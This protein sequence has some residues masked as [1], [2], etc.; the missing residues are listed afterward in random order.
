[1]I[2]S[3]SL[4]GDGCARASGP[5]TPRVTGASRAFDV[6]YER[7]W[8]AA[9]QT[10]IALEYRP[11]FVQAPRGLLVAERDDDPSA[12]RTFT[13]APIGALDQRWWS[14]QTRLLITCRS[15]EPGRT[16]VQVH[17]SLMARASPVGMSRRRTADLVPLDSNG[18]P[19]RRWLDTLDALLSG[20]W[21]DVATWTAK[22]S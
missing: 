14:L 11:V 6:P 13:D 2:L 20:R 21:P 5:S 16:L 8:D 17:S 1:M 4:A 19:E 9:M 12:I 18:T 7:V 10:V 22:P 3:V 15:V